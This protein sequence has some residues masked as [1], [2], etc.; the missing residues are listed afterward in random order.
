MADNIAPRKVAKKTTRKTTTRKAPTRVT[1]SATKSKENNLPIFIGIGIFILVLG[2]SA[3][4]GYSDKGSIN[5]SGVISE[6]KNSGT[7]EEKAAIKKERRGT[8]K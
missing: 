1:R 6:K 3:A 7:E 2:V 8:K 4:V 5:V